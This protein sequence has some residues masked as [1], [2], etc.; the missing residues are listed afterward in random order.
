MFRLGKYF[1]LS[2]FFRLFLFLAILKI[3]EVTLLRQAKKSECGT[4]QPNSCIADDNVLNE[5]YTRNTY[6]LQNLVQT[7]RVIKTR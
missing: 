3:Q 2:S 6:K 4:A 1:N 7:D 5:Q